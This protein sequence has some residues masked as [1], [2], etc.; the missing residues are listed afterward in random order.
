MPLCDVP[1]ASGTVG[2]HF[3]CT[4]VP[5]MVMFQYIEQHLHGNTFALTFL[6]MLHTVEL[7]TISMIEL[8]L[9]CN[10]IDVS[11]SCPGCTVPTCTGYVDQCILVWCMT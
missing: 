10:T 8:G 9:A 1:G 4:T 3:A 5:Y 6:F 11:T 7:R 2:G